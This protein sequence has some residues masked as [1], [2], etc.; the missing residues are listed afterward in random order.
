MS[1]E[2]APD[3]GVFSSRAAAPEAAAS[4]PSIEGVLAAGPLE[5]KRGRGERVR[6]VSGRRHHK[7]AKHGAQAPS[8]HPAPWA[9]AGR[10]GQAQEWTNPVPRFW[11]GHPAPAS[12]SVYESWESPPINHIQIIKFLKYAFL[13]IYLFETTPPLKQPGMEPM[14]RAVEAESATGPPGWSQCVCF[15]L[16]LNQ[17]KRTMAHR[18]Q[19]RATHKKFKDNK[20]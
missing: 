16:R 2:M 19:D 12:R 7:P 11:R 8:A 18:N 9:M 6:D 10:R 14:P 20:K 17:P 4:A 15:F 1:S 3:V 5:L 13:C